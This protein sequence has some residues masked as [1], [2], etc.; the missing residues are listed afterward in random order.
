MEW[1]HFGMVSF[2]HELMQHVFSCHHSKKNFC[3]K[4]HIWILFFMYWFNMLNQSIFYKKALVSFFPHELMNCVYS[5]YSL[6]WCCSHKY[7]TLILFCYS[8]VK[9]FIHK[10]L[11][12]FMTS[13]NESLE[14]SCS[15]KLE[16]FISLMNW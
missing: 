11:N 3:G 13:W 10:H 7:C 5:Y 9:M 1:I 6:N 14:N 12:G 8:F 16:C 15:R 4:F 2:L